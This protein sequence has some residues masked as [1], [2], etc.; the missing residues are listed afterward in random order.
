[1]ATSRGGHGVA[2]AVRTLQGDEGAVMRLGYE[3]NSV[4]VD[5][6]VE[7][8]RG[9][10]TPVEAVVMVAT[11][12]AAAKFIDKTRDLYPRM[13]YTNLSFVGSTAL[14]NELLLLGRRYTNGVIVTQVVPAIDSYASGILTYKT[15]LAKYFPGAPADYVSLEGYVAAS[16]LPEGLKRMGLGTPIGFSPRD[17][18]GSHKVWGT[19]LN[20]QGSFQPIDL[21]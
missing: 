17:H 16:V 11:Y 20:D 12:R 9:L 10:K 18:Q 21:E 7:L 8:L 19:Q 15:V 5:N 2:R 1:M 6:A 13:I 3:R 14:A 4:D